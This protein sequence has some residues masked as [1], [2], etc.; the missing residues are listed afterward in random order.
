[1]SEATPAP[2]AAPAA[3]AAPPAV[4][5]GK[6]Q[7]VNGL[8]KGL[9]EIRG[10]MGLPAL[11]DGPLVGSFFKD[12]ATAEAEYTS[13][14]SIFSKVGKPKPEA[15]AATPQAKPAETPIPTPGPALNGNPIPD[16]LDV[17]SLIGKAGLDVDA[18]S[19][20]WAQNGRLTAEQYDAIKKVHPAYTPKLVDQII[21]G[22]QSEANNTLTK[23]VNL[24]GGQESYE[25]AF[26]WASENLSDAQKAKL[27]KSVTDSALASNPEAA[28]EAFESLLF[29]YQKAGGRVGGATFQAP[30]GVVEGTPATGGVTPFRTVSEYNAALSRYQK[31]VASTTEA[32]RLQATTED[33]LYRMPVR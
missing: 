2:A 31:G 27:R 33:M 28:I 6:Y 12:A 17:P 16:D 10:A 23:M 5:A 13:L 22:I 25:Q 24:A 7:D 21:K 1:M 4:Y 32:Q 18:L 30:Q 14:N 3:P 8:E 20:E 26:K 29:K 9:R 11:P 19:S 15:P